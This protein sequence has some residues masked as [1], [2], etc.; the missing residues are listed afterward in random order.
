MILQDTP[1]LIE[2]PL[3]RNPFCLIDCKVKAM[4]CWKISTPLGSILLSKP[5][6]NVL[7]HL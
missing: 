1:G 3:Q 2:I 5:C 6:I 7:K 4:L